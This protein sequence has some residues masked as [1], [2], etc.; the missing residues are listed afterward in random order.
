MRYSDTDLTFYL[1]TYRDL[2]RA[3]W[4]LDLVRIAYP[5]ARIVVDVDGDQDPGWKRLETLHRAEVYYGERLFLL[6]RGGA[7]VNRMLRHHLDDPEGRRWIFRI[8]TD[9][10]IRR[11]FNYL[12]EADYFGSYVEGLVQGGFIG[13]TREALQ[14][15]ERSRCLERPDLRIASTWQR[16]NPII[17]EKRVRLGLLSF[18][19]LVAWAMRE[20]GIAGERFPEVMSRW[21]DP[22]PTSVDVA[23]AHPCKHIPVNRPHI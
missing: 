4:C 12:P 6:A 2:T 22:V 5:A 18:D 19:W 10:E 16:G 3:I 15:I 7:I 23:V 17:A 11:R 9:T 8:D 1:I 13:M 20:A 21:R 14:R